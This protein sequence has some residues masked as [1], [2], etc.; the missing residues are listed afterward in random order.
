MTQIEIEQNGAVL[1]AKITNPP[2]GF[3]DPETEMELAALLDRVDADEDIRSVVFTGGMPG[4]FIRHYNVGVLAETAAKMSARGMQF[5]T[6]RSVPESPYHVCLRRMTESP[7]AFIAALNGI[8]MGGGFELAL[9]CDIRIA[10]DG[11][12]DLGLPEINVGLLPGAGGTQR[13][14]RLIGE[15]RAFE[16]IARGRTVSPAEALEWGIISEIVDRDVVARGMEI[17]EELSRKPMRAFRNIKQLMR[18]GLDRPLEE[19]LADERTLFCDVMVDGET[20]ERMS[21]LN[22]RQRDIRDRD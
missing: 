8:A 4:V 14:P 6:S 11:D 20:M 10:L 3:M 15:G 9:A 21:E 1:L 18:R 5:D 16:M 7:V 12:Y 13:L 22:V 17:A 2:Q 19:G